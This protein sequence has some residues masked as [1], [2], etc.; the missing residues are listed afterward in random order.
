M[1]FAQADPEGD[2]KVM[3]TCFTAEMLRQMQ[4][5]EIICIL[6]PEA[7]RTHV[8]LIRDCG[9]TWSLGHSSSGRAYVR[10]TYLVHFTNF[11]MY[12]VHVTPVSLPL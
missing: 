12:T 4:M 8:A 3:Q 1:T 7:S 2:V 6:G 5:C 9:D 11:A 10:H